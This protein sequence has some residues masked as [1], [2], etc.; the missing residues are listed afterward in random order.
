MFT[1]RNWILREI[2]VVDDGST[3]TTPEILKGI[4]AETSEIKLFRN[5]VKYNIL[6]Y[7]KS[8]ESGGVGLGKQ[9]K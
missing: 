4:A 5:Q 2:V 9:S 8:E 7:G 6:R 1:S 3:D